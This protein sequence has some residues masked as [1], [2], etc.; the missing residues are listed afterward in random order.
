M[1]VCY[2]PNSRQTPVQLD[3][4]QFLPVIAVEATIWERVS[5]ISSQ[6][7]LARWPLNFPKRTFRISSS[8]SALCQLQTR[9]GR[10]Q[11]R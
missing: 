3:C 9:A 1:F 7:N 4:P 5:S 6:D 2:C 11:L 10:I 8:M